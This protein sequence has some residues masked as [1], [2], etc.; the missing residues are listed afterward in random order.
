MEKR[1]ECGKTRVASLQRLTWHTNDVVNDDGEVG[2]ALAFQAVRVA[3]RVR[4]S[5]AAFRLAR[6]ADEKTLASSSAHRFYVPNMY[7][8]KN[9]GK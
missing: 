8:N 5:V 9:T 3:N 6:I 2:V 7:P 4:K 1:A